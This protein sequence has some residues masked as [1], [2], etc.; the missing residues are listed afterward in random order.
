MSRNRSA[1]SPRPSCAAA[2]PAFSAMPP[3]SAPAQNALSPA[4]VSTTT[5]T[6]SSACARAHRVA[7]SLH[8]AVRHRVAPLGPVDRHPGDA[9]ADLVQH[10]VRSLTGSPR[11]SPGCGYATRGTVAGHARARDRRRR[12]AADPARSRAA[13]YKRLFETELA[14]GLAARRRPR[15]SSSC[16]STS[17]SRALLAQRR[18]RPARRVVRADPRVR[19]LEPRAARHGRSC[20]S[21]S[22]ATRS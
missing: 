19:A 6:S 11:R 15:R 4:P 12:R 20:S 10:L 22:R 17:R 5:R 21:A 13:R 7:Q 1:S 16:S 3:R 14:L 18:L 2:A 9:A 8:H